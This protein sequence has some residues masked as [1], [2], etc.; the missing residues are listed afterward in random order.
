MFS[1]RGGSARTVY[2]FFPCL[3]NP[4]AFSMRRCRVSGALAPDHRRVPGRQRLHGRAGHDRRE[5][6]DPGV[7]RPGRLGRRKRPGSHRHPGVGPAARRGRTGCRPFESPSARRDRAARA[8]RCARAHDER[9]V[10][11]PR[12]GPALPHHRAPGGDLGLRATA[13]RSRVGPQ[14]HDRPGSPSPQRR[15]GRCAHGRHARSAIGGGGRPLGRSLATLRP[16]VPELYARDDA[17]CVGTLS[18]HTESASSGNFHDLLAAFVE[19]G[20]RFLVVGAH[21]LAAHGVPRVT[22][23]L[24]G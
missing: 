18:D 20:V 5:R 22:G 7:V 14:E 9:V 3:K 13:G 21:A 2:R 24:Q 6:R 19:A 17:G 8:R 23:D 12:G 10:P 11:G 16:A 4:T 1:G 15:S